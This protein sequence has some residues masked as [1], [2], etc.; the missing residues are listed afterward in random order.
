MKVPQASTRT[1]ASANMTPMIDV[2]FLL[3]IF[4]LV[5]SHLAKQESRT[6]LDLPSAATHRV[7]DPQN[8]RLTINVANDGQLQVAG[9]VVSISRL[10][11]LLLGHREQEQAAASVRIRTDK[12][13]PYGTIEPLLREIALIGIT[14]V[15]FAVREDATQ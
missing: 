2:V 8:Q 3:I 9:S 7:D 5:S 10:R 14:D 11:E 13:V 6:P 4:F 15:T 1:S 12:K